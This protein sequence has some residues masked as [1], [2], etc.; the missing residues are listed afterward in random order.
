ML[1]LKWFSVKYCWSKFNLFFYPCFYRG[2]EPLDI[3]T[4]CLGSIQACVALLV[5]KHLVSILQARGM[6]YL[7]HCSPPIVHRDL[8]SSNLLVDK[9]WTVK[10]ML[11]FNFS[12]LH[13]FSVWLSFL[14]LIQWYAALVRVREKKC[15]NSIFPITMF[16]LLIY[17]VQSGRWLW[18]FTSETWNISANKNWKRNSKC[19]QNLFDE[20]G[21][22]SPEEWDCHKHWSTT[23]SAYPL[24]ILYTFYSPN[25]WLRRW[26]VM[27]RQ[28][29]S[30][31]NKKIIK[32]GCA[33]YP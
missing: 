30:T 31:L 5:L 22:Y 1:K 26:Y 4:R 16:S 24:K 14:L 23:F 18:S 33:S 28:M 25:G 21:R 19:E 15:W 3:K 10:V 13:V 8:K 27:N 9:N 6:N 11:K 7:H 2:P 32:D 12:N 29:K 20:Y 17:V